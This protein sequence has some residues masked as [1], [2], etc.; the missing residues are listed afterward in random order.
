[1]L[2]QHNLAAE[3]FM[4]RLQLIMVCGV[5]FAAGLTWQLSSDAKMKSGHHAKASIEQ[6]ANKLLS[7]SGN[8]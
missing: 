4:I 7:N 8:S 5:I 3:A 1:M 2:K 6:P